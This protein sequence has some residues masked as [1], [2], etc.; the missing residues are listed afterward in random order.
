MQY[1]YGAASN[2]SVTVRVLAILVELK[3]PIST[4]VPY[5]YTVQ[6][7]GDQTCGSA[8][9]DGAESISC[10]RFDACVEHT[11]SSHTCT[12]T[13]FIRTL[14]CHLSPRSRSALLRRARRPGSHGYSFCRLTTRV[15]C[16]VHFCTCGYRT[17]RR[18]RGGLAN[19]LIARSKDR[20]FT[21][22]SC[23]HVLYKYK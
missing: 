8:P 2:H 16:T 14:P 11:V 5:K 4:R 15:R 23:L 18:C 13:A 9:N 3:R 19:K 17:L 1:Y 21:Y 10:I 12:G 7:N 6:I 20:Y 22:V